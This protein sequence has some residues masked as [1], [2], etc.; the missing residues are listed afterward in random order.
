MKQVYIYVDDIREDDSFFNHNFH[1][2]WKVI[3]CRDYEQ[4]IQALRIYQDYDE[5]F[6]DLDHDLGFDDD[7]YEYNGCDICKY[8]VEN[9]IKI[10][11]FHIHSMNPVGAQNMRNILQDYGVEEYI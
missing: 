5:I 4:T 2:G 1:T 9:Q 3:I 6:I 8:I 10:N 11:G 7:N